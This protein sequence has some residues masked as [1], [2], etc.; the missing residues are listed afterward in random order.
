YMFGQ[1]IEVHSV[2]GDLWISF[3]PL[4]ALFAFLLVG[5]ATYAVARAVTLQSCPG[6]VIYLLLLGVWDTFFSPLLPSSPTLALLFAVTA[7]PL[8]GNLS[9]QDVAGPAERGAAQ[10]RRANLPGLQ[11]VRDG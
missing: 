1:K 2:L 11:G 9:T 7:I 6:V 10:L 8:A 3:G 5:S 4:A